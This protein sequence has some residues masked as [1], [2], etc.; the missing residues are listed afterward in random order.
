M[1]LRDGRSKMSKSDPSDQSRINLDDAPD[2]I[3]QKIRRAKTDTH[4][5]IS[6][7]PE[8][9]PEVANLLEIHAALRGAGATAADLPA[10]LQGAGMAA[11]KA[12]LTDLVIARLDPIRRE[13]ERLRADPA[14]VD[15]VLADGTR[16]ARARA[17]TKLDA[18]QRAVGFAL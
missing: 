16:R 8:T 3:R 1:S 2:A 7:E 10:H 14:Y 4:A 17:R 9:R 11:F 15:A 18:V 5:H 12:D 13:L 6:Y